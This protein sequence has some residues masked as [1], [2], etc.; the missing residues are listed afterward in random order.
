[1]KAFP[2]SFPWASFA[3]MPLDV[4]ADAY[5]LAVAFIEAEI[6]A[7]QDARDG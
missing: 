4:Y 6:K 1:M 3:S 2:G 7:R 5:G